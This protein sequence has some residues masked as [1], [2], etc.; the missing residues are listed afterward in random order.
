MAVSYVSA[1]MTCHKRDMGLVA[2]LISGIRNLGFGLLEAIFLR[3]YYPKFMSVIKGII[4]KNLSAVKASIRRFW[5]L[6]QTAS[7]Q[8]LRHYFLNFWLSPISSCI[9]SWRFI[10]ELA[11]IYS[12]GFIIMV[13]FVASTDQYL[14][15]EIWAHLNRPNIFGNPVGRKRTKRVNGHS[16]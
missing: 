3:I 9:P 12:C 13:L 7:C 2:G 15:N 6:L 1:P 16:T 8:R 5:H 4:I 10:L 11:N 14:T